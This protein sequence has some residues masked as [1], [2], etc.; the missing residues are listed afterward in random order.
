MIYKTIATVAIWV[1][2]ASIPITSLIVYKDF[3]I[4][5]LGIILYTIIAGFLAGMTTEIIWSK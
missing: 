5:W 4:I 2:W 1:A 3:P